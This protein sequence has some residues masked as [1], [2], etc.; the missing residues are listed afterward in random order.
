MSF[1][2]MASTVEVTMRLDKYMKLRQLAMFE[3]LEDM[4]GFGGLYLVEEDGIL[5]A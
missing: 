2:L 3:E 1:G 4:E 5:R